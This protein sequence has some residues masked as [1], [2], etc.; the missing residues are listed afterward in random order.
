M[1]KNGERHEER[2]REY[3][4]RNDD[5]EGLSQAEF[6]E[7]QPLIPVGNNVER[8]DDLAVEYDVWYDANERLFE[9]EVAALQAIIPDGYG[10]EVGA[11]S[12]RFMKA[13][14]IDRGIDPAKNMRQIAKTHEVLLDEGVAEDL[15][16]PDGRFDYVAFLTSLEFVADKD[17]ALTEA[18]RVLRPGGWLI[19]AFLNAASDEGRQLVDAQKDVPFFEYASFLTADQLM[20]L[21]ESHGFSCHTVSQV[22][23][24]DD[25]F[26]VLEGHGDGLY[27]VLAAIRP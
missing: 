18:K 21:I 14:G 12:G 11:G 5:N 19:I 8:Y 25:T 4:V 15:P 10:L 6:T 2:T 26:E 13:L 24:E 7:I 20:E 1:N 27:T 23:G 3:D 22:V 9:A 17:T 16:F